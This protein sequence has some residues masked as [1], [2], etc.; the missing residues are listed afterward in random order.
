[1]GERCEWGRTVGEEAV[2]TW[3]EQQKDQQGWRQWG[4]QLLWGGSWPLQHRRGGL[5]S[6]P[7]A[8]PGR[9]LELLPVSVH[10]DPG[11]CREVAWSSTFPL[12]RKLRKPAGQSREAAAGA[13]SVFRELGQ[14]GASRIH[15]KRV[16]RGLWPA[17]C[18]QSK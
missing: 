13:R 7:G 17:S 18:S 8:F 12:G 5:V 1:M 6:L 2:L 16:T 14:I 10:W 11:P 9:A 3:G 4:N 15:G